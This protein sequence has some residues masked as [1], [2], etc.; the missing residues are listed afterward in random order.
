MRF[1]GPSPGGECPE[2]CPSSLA[3]FAAAAILCGGLDRGQGIRGERGG[4][5]LCGAARAGGRPAKSLDDAA[6]AGVSGRR[7]V[8]GLFVRPPDR[9]AVEA[10][11]CQ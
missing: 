10:D 5:A 6:D 7:R 11:R 8:P 4:L 1:A 2:N 3:A 9:E